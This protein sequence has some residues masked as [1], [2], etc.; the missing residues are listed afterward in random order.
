VYDQQSHCSAGW[1]ANAAARLAVLLADYNDERGILYAANR[2]AT[3][4]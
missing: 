4:N 3:A 2:I 1:E